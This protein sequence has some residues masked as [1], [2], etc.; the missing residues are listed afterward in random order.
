M[1]QVLYEWNGNWPEGGVQIQGQFMGRTFAGKVLISPTEARR[2]ANGYLSMDVAMAIVADDPILVWGERPVW[3]M[4]TSL[5][6][7][8]WG[9]VA[10]LGT[11]DVDA[12]TG[13]IIPLTA[14]QIAAIQER[15]NE[16]ATRLTLETAPS[17]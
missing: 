15:A 1:I 7:A 2:G 6:L 11:I 9:R 3:R 16:L 4:T 10:Q 5:L 12:M 14:E 13:D 17:G 8:D